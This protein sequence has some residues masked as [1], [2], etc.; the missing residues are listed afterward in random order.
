MTHNEQQRGNDDSPSSGIVEVYLCDDDHFI[1]EAL[2]SLLSTY[3]LSKP[4]DPVS[5]IKVVGEAAN[6]REALQMVANH[7]PGRDPDGC[8]N[9]GDGWH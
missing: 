6:G 4:N 1:R 8:T 5:K 9:A 7:Q 3:A 2:K